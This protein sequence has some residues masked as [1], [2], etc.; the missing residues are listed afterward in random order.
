MRTVI[1]RS[2]TTYKPKEYLYISTRE[3]PKALDVATAD[4]I[5]N[6]IADETLR[7][8]FYNF[9]CS[10]NE[11]TINTKEKPQEE[12]EPSFAKFVLGTSLFLGFV[13]FACISPEL[14]QDWR[15]RVDM[16]NKI[17][18]LELEKMQKN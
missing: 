10:Y 8:S 9:H 11:F 2:F 18:K 14:H 7:K 13:I 5:Y 6:S 4:C 16:R 15:D 3:L 12:K 1:R 17:Q